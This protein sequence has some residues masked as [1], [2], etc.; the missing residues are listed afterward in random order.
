MTLPKVIQEEMGERTK[1]SM[2]EL[3]WGM[4]GHHLN[5]APGLKSIHRRE[6]GGIETS[7]QIDSEQ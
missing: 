2:M 4:G 3:R 6:E 1:R 7:S 5:E